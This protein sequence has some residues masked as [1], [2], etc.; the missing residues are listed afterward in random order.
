MEHARHVF[1]AVLLLIAGLVVFF[2]VRTL[3]VPKSFGEA[4]APY[5]FDN[6]AEQMKIR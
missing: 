2:I 5:R 1:R 4:H 3:L 6:V